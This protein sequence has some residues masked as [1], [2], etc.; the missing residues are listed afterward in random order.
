MVDE[1]RVQRLLDEIFDTDRAPEEVCRDCPELLPEVRRR[2][3]KIHAVDAELEA[4]FPTPGPTQAPYPPAP[5]SPGADLPRIP[6]YEPEAVLG[7]GGMGIVYKA[8]DLRLSRPVALKMLLA[9]AYAG[10]A[11]RERFL[12]EAEA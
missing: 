8:R 5:G 2:W 10:A 9:G 4:L 7:H 6:G 1:P 3:Q 12:R 11:N